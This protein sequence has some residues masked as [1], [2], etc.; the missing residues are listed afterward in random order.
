ME[1]LVCRNQSLNDVCVIIVVDVF[2]ARKEV[3]G[4]EGVMS[5]APVFLEGLEGDSEFIRFVAIYQN[6]VGEGMDCYSDA[7]GVLIYILRWK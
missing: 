5:W 3:P 7:V 6:R 4:A 1:G 2:V